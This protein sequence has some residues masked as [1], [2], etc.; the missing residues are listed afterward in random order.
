M[1]L[2][3][4]FDGEGHHEYIPFFHKNVYQFLRGQSRDFVKDQWC[5]EHK[6]VLIRI[7]YE[8]LTEEKVW[9]L[10]LN[11]RIEMT[12]YIAEELRREI[13]PFYPPVDDKKELEKAKAKAFRKAQYQRAKENKKRREK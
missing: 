12:T 2:A 1:R 9:E 7:N 11:R 6:V 8:D 5:Q 4:E 3:F 10:V 13:P